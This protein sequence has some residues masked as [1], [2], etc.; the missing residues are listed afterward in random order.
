MRLKGAVLR[1]L[2]QAAQA[3]ECFLRS[4]EIARAQ[5]ARWWA[6]HRD[7]ARGPVADSGRAQDARGVLSG[8]YG[9]FTEGFDTR[10][11]ATRERCSTASREAGRRDRRLGGVRQDRRGRWRSTMAR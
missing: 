8:V 1:D 11:S 2:R 9:W 7:F 5:N 4:L 10:I 6:S 3:E